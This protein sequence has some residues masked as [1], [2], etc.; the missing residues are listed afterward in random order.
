[1]QQDALQG[2]ISLLISFVKNQVNQIKPA[3]VTHKFC[4]FEK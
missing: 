1:M 3:G 2:T 4:G